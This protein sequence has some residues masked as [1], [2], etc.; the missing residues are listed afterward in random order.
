MNISESNILLAEFLGYKKA[1]DSYWYKEGKPPLTILL[2]D[3]SWDWLMEVVEKIEGLEKPITDNPNLI[4]KFEIYEI[5][6]QHRHIKIYAH[7][8]VTKEV[9]DLRSSDSSTKIEA[10]YNAC[11]KFVE[12]YNAQKWMTTSMRKYL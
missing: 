6:I 2:F 11:V 10:V 7:G 8:E 3:T 12:W 4:G 1:S 5:H 9:V